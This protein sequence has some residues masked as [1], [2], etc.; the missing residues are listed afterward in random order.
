[1]GKTPPILLLFPRLPT[2]PPPPP[3]LFMRRQTPHFLKGSNTPCSPLCLVIL[4]STLSLQRR[5]W[6]NPLLPH[7]RSHLMMSPWLPRQRCTGLLF[8]LRQT[9]GSQIGQ[10]R[11]ASG[12]APMTWQ[13]SSKTHS[14]W[15]N[16]TH[17][18]CRHKNYICIFRDQTQTRGSSS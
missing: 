15:H 9:S 3:L 10:A 13:C 16:Q 12:H 7:V 6:R 4:L 5:P 2:P 11:A 14:N 8:L 17:H 18:L 1:M